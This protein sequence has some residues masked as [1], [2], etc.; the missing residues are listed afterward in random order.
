MRSRK[1]PFKRKLSNPDSRPV[2]KVRIS[3]AGVLAQVVQGG[4]V[5][6]SVRKL[7]SIGTPKLQ[8]SEQVGHD[9][10][11]VLINMGVTRVVYDRGRRPYLGCV[12]RLATAARDSGLLF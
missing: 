2:L 12:A 8:L 1:K 5:I 7:K 3:N 4:N 10:A 9:I 11:N 6:A